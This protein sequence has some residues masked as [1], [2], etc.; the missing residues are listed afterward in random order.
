VQTTATHIELRDRDGDKA[1]EAQL[2]W[3]SV[4]GLHIHAN[5]PR[6]DSKYAR[7]DSEVPQKLREAAKTKPSR[8][9][10]GYLAIVTAEKVYRLPNTIEGYVRLAHEVRNRAG[11]AAAE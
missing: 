8:L 11:L 3:D 4:L 6:V 2:P 7:A 9:A 10:S 5:M 1:I